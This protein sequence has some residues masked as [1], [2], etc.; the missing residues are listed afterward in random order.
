[1][2]T[3]SRSKKLY[4]ITWSS[5]YRGLPKEKK[6]FGPAAEEDLVKQTLQWIIEN[7]KAIDIDAV[8]E[9]ME[10]NN[11]YNV[12][13]DDDENTKLIETLLSQCNSVKDLKYI[14]NKYDSYYEDK[15]GWK[16]II[17]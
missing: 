15:E 3:I 9:I 5:N 8:R 1:M 17:K 11:E 13:D 6:V 10:E 4:T 16:L 7:N 14:C 2:S 12:D